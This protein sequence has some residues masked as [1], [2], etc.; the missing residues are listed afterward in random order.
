VQAAVPVITALSPPAT[1]AGDSALSLTVVGTGFAPDAQV[2]WNGQP[3]ETRWISA[4]ELRAQVVTALLNR[5]QIVG[6]AVANQFPD[7]R[8][9][10]IRAF[11][12]ESR[13]LQVYLP[14]VRR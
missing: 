11:T 14:I 1:S 4:T 6:I 12:V 8:I 13:P 10:A 5:G 9:S 7:G 2:L 3:L